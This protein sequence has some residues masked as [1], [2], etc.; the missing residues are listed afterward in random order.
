[1]LLGNVLLLGVA[2]APISS[3]GAAC[4]EGREERY[5]GTQNGLDRGRRGAWST[6][7]LAAPTTQMVARMLIPSTR[8]PMILTHSPVEGLF[9]ASLS[10]TAHAYQVSLELRICSNMV[11]GPLGSRTP[12][13]QAPTLAREPLRGPGTESAPEVKNLG[14]CSSPGATIAL[15]I[16]H[17]KLL[18]CLSYPTRR[19]YS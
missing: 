5:P 1:M 16:S 4:R 18:I 3:P 7:F 19:R 13:G 6:V 2:E 11:D 15:A 10:L 17:V 9:I 14:G 12:P 8:H